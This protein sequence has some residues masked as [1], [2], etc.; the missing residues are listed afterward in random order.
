MEYVLTRREMLTAPAAFSPTEMVLRML[1]EK[2]APIKKHGEA[3][4]MYEVE[5]GFTVEAS[6]LYDN[7]YRFRF[8][9]KSAQ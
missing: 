8:E 5:R 6:V 2:G 4:V 3:I 1:Y 7:S 9:R